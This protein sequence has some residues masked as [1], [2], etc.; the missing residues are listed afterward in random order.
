MPPVVAVVVANDPG[1]WFDVALDALAR[2]TYSTMSVLVIDTGDDD[3]TDRAADVMPT[4]LVHRDSSPVGFGAAANRATRLVSGAHF[5]LFLHDDVV[6]EPDAVEVMVA[7]ALRSNAGIVGPKLV[8]W[9]NPR[10]L[11][12]VGMAVDKMGVP[13][14]YADPG[15][16]DQEQ[17]DRV[18]DAFAVQGGCTLVRTDLFETLGGF[19]E[20]ID[21][22]GEDIDLCWRAHVVGARVLVAPDAVGRHLEA[23]G[24]RRPEIRRRQRLSRHRLRTISTSYGW[25]DLLRVLPQAAAWSLGEILL[26]LFTGRFEQARDIAG[27]WTWNLRRSGSILAARRRMK[28]LRRTRDSDIRRLQV[29]GSARFTA[30]LRGQIGEGSRLQDL[31]ARTREVAGTWSD[32]PRRQ[33]IL[34][35][36]AMVIVLLFGARHLITRGIAQF[37][38]FDALPSRGALLSSYASGWSEVELGVSGVAPAGVGLLGL[39]ATAL[40]GATGLLRTLLIVGLLP[41]GWF[42][43]W[44]LG[45]PLGSRRGRLVAALLYAA[46]PLG[47][48]AIAL[49]RWDVLLLY[50]AMPFA[51][52]RLARLIGVAPY[53]DRHGSPGPG[54]PHRS[55]VHQ[56]VSL[57]LLLGVVAAFEP[58]ILA[59]VP[60]LAVVLV[61]AS[62][63]TGNLWLP[64]RAVL[65]A[66]A[67][68]A[69]GAALNALWWLRWV[70]DPVGL[71]ET[72]VGPERGGPTRLVDLFRLA[73]GPTG[74]S[75][76]LLALPIVAA[77]AL[78]LGRDWRAAWAPRAWSISL[79]AIGAA[80][81]SANDL[82]PFATPDAAILLVPAGVGFAWAGGLGFAAF[83]LDVPRFGRSARRAAIGLGVTALVL[84]IGPAFGAAQSGNYGAPSTDLRGALRFI[85]AEPALGD[86]RVVWLGEADLLPAPGREVSS[87]VWTTTSTGGLP[88]V[89]ANWTTPPTDAAD[90]LVNTLAVGLDGETARI[91]RL[92]APFAVRYVVVPQAVAPTFAGGEVRPI[93]PAVTNTLGSQ[94]DLRRIATDPSVVVFENVEW[95]PVRAATTADN[96][97]LGA[98][99]LTGLAV[100]DA[101]DWSAAV[102]Q[103]ITSVEFE[104]FVASDVMALAVGDAGDWVLSVGGVDLEPQQREGPTSWVRLWSTP[105]GEVARLEHRSASGFGWL[106]L[107]HWIGWVV[108]ARIAVAE[109]R[110]PSDTGE[111]EPEPEPEFEPDVDMDGRAAEEFTV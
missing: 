6:L 53:G 26:S 58:F 39:G 20:G 19:D 7:E 57:G 34:G 13:A 94:L 91:G 74:D 48:D 55:L 18:R 50:A 37:G 67:A 81:V 43:A 104:G 28:Q 41:L 80:W 71:W 64:A 52:L 36:A 60:A 9:H 84:A 29:R 68:S 63:L 93:D 107:I 92:L 111:S 12:S 30:Y 2:Q 10:E 110:R 72:A 54:V 101:G 99:D 73:V 95:R 25:L 69:V 102:R 109:R 98:T 75:W 100:A 35:W 5:M 82:L 97:S 27:A 61:V 85:A 77:F 31:A 66:V 65:L 103:R 47:Y 33:A 105:A 46:V 89:R 87:G 56:V 32:G 23:L 42:G 22:L 76:L 59:I 40:L 79:A 83:E 90:E 17:H 8:S 24:S 4:A 38:Q 106:L 3:V 14:P 21:Y 45:G 51:V 108:V 78:V 70:D 88:D 86:F 16:L 49:G 15:E 62:G 1:D 96:P 11:R 44:R